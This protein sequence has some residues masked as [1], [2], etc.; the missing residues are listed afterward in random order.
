MKDLDNLTAKLLKEHELRVAAEAARLAEEQRVLEAAQ[1]VR[2]EEARIAAEKAAQEAKAREDIF[3]AATDTG[4]S[5]LG[6]WQ[7]KAA[8]G[9][10]GIRFGDRVKIGNSYSISGVL[11]DPAKP[12]TEK[13]FSATTSGDGSDKSPFILEVKVVDGPGVVLKNSEWGGARETTL[14]LLH[15]GTRYVVPL[16]FSAD[17][18]F[19]SGE[20]PES[21]RTRHILRGPVALVFSKERSQGAGAGKP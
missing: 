9:E 1:K 12:S 5:Y 18:P 2:D 21:F 19:F 6:V 4:K 14:G 7:G 10:V 15:S 11:F 16:V 13:A 17:G 3:L 20:I 8:R